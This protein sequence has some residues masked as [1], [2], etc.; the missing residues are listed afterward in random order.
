MKAVTVS[1]PGSTPQIS[2][3]VEIPE[4]GEGQILVKLHYTAINPVDTIMA[5]SGAMV[6]SWPFVPGCD[7]AGTVLKVGPHAVSALG[8]SWTI[9]DQVFGCTRLGS[10]GFAAWAE[11]LLF[12]AHLCIPVPP[13]LTLAEAAG[14]G[15]GLLTAALGIFDRLKIALPDPANLPAP[16][17]KWALVFGGAGSVGQ[18]AVQLFNIAGFKVVA[19]SSAKS[20]ELLRSIGA[21]ATIDYKNSGEEIVEK[22]QSITNGSLNYALDAVSVNNGLLS[23]I[24]DALAPSTSGLRHYTTTNTWD[25]L[26]FA[27]ESSVSVVDPIQLGPI[28]QPDAVDTNNSL[29]TIIPA[30]YKLLESGAIKPSMIS[31][32]GEG[33]EGILKAWDVQKSGVKG[34]TKVLVHISGE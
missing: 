8:K 2:S 24:Y 28:G 30:L 11:Y 12:D 17:D 10:K 16:H 25:P 33:I 4:P 5:T 13:N 20:F 3:D 31:I 6:Q 26:S 7:A 18:F 21:S 27:S 15:V 9:G 19:T 29:K 23:S 14:T 1:Q 22:V 34:S 32:E